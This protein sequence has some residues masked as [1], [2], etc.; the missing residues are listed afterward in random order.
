MTPT[1][2]I[3]KVPLGDVV[4]KPYLV[5]SFPAGFSPGNDPA[6]HST[7]GTVSSD[8]VIRYTTP[9]TYAD[10]AYDMVLVV[11]AKTLITDAIKSGPPQN[12]PPARNG[13][14]A[15]F[16]ADM[17]T[18]RPGDPGIPA[19]LVRLNV[20]GADA[21]V[22]VANKTAVD[23]AEILGAITNTVMIIP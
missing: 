4:G 21:D 9:K 18:V 19:G 23:P 2:A 7:W 14:L 20:E 12:A 8:L 11:Y 3:I 16:T 6:I 5:A 15:T 10:G 1:V 17:S 13:D 22:A